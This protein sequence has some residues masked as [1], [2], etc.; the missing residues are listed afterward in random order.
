MW[1]AVVVAV[2]ALC[3]GGWLALAYYRALPKSPAQHREMA[4]DFLRRKSRA[5]TFEVPLEAAQQKAMSGLSNETAS[6]QAQVSE[7]AGTRSRVGQDL[8]QRLS[9]A[10][11]WET[12]YRALGQELWLSF[13]CLSSLDSTVQR[14]GLQLADQAREAALNDAANGWLAARICEG[15]LLPYLDKADASGKAPLSRDYLLNISIQTFHQAEENK[16]F[17]E[18]AQRFIRENPTAAEADRLRVEIGQVLEDQGDLAGAVAQYQAVK[19]RNSFGRV[20]R[21]LP[22]LEVQAKRQTVMRK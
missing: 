21:R 7:A 4:F 10:G 15:F 13:Q 19:N 3:A 18:L 2:A 20:F 5:K 12:I 14:A 1:A 17:M 6:S 16:R 22:A 11:S 9:E 8:H